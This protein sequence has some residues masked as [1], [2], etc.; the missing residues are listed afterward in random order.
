MQK[1]I[2]VIF[3]PKKDFF[4]LY[5][6]KSKNYLTSLFKNIEYF[7][8]KHD[9]ETEKE[10]FNQMVAKY[11]ADLQNLQVVLLAFVVVD[12]FVLTLSIDRYSDSRRLQVQNILGLLFYENSIKPFI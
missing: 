1:V 3:L 10:K 2:L 4:I 7:R 5:L 8:L 12:L 11:Q 9:L 6:T